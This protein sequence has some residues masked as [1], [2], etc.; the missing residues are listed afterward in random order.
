MG[1]A[2]LKFLTQ[3]ERTKVLRGGVDESGGDDIPTASD[4]GWNSSV[5]LVEAQ[6]GESRLSCGRKKERNKGNFF[7]FFLI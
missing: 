3:A 4:G 2:C 1:Q 5:V 6:L 7:F